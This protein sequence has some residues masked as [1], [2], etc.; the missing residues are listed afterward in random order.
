MP[1]EP[2]RDHIGHKIDTLYLCAIYQKA[3]KVECRCCFH[4]AILPGVSTWWLFERRGWEMELSAAC[5]RFF[6]SSCLS[7]KREKVHNPHVRTTNEKPTAD[8]F[9]WPD[10][11]TWTKMV[12]RFRS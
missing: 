2:E 5:K 8:P 9:R 7:K 6:C 11:R 10:E 12:S 1:F 3:L 4:W